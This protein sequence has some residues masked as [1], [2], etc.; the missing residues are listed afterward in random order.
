MDGRAG[1]DMEAVAADRRKEL[2][3]RG[4]LLNQCEYFPGWG[5]R[6]EG[7]DGKSEKEF[8]RAGQGG[9]ESRDGDREDMALS[10]RVRCGKGMESRGR[11]CL[12]G[13]SQGHLQSGRGFE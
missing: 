8:D 2:G 13:L 1:A 6:A 3:N 5:F 12:C 4:G 10:P 11:Q 9:L 7:R